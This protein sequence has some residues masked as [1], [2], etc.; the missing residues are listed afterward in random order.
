MSDV[1]IETNSI[2]VTALL[3]QYTLFCEECEERKRDSERETPR[4]RE[5]QREKHTNYMGQGTLESVN[6]NIDETCRR[7]AKIRENLRSANSLNAQK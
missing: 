5:R 1:N 2:A 3:T 7:S 4:E 6:I